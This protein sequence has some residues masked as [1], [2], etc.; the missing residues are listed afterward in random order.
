MLM[1]KY[2]LDKDQLFEI[3]KEEN[4]K[5][6]FHQ[7]S[8]LLAE[9]NNVHEVV[10]LLTRN[11]KF[12]KYLEE[13]NCNYYVYSYSVFWAIIDYIFDLY[14]NSDTESIINILLYLDKISHIANAYTKDLLFA[15]AL[16]VFDKHLDILPQIVELMP[17]HLKSLFLQ[18]F[19]DY[20]K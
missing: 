19:S 3:A 2:Y 20:L 6:G 18:H 4:L 9:E 17:E 12:C 15:W 8:Y 11:P 10:E 14:Q 1:N 7:E 13:N 16:E 5:N